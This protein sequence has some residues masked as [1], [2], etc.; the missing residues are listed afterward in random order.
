MPNNDSMNA[1]KKEP[2]NNFFTRY[3]TIKNEMEYYKSYLKGKRVHCIYDNPNSSSFFDY[4]SSNFEKLGLE[5]LSRAWFDGKF[6]THGGLYLQEY[7]KLPTFKYNVADG[8]KAKKDYQKAGIEECI[9]ILDNSD[10]ICIDTPF[11]AFTSIVENI[12]DT[13]KAFIMPT[14]VGKIVSGSKPFSYFVRGKLR[15]GYN[16][17][18]KFKELGK[19]K[20]VSK[21]DSCFITNLQVNRHIEPLYLTMVYDSDIYQKAD[22][23]DVILIHGKR[24]LRHLYPL[25]I[26][27]DYNGYMCVH[28]RFLYYFDPKIWDI[29]E[30]AGYFIKAIGCNYKNEPIKMNNKNGFLDLVIKRKGEIHGC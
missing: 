27:I 6:R 16:I 17:K 18:F 26:P 28:S 2:N 14:S 24:K 25:E 11:S 10:F 12:M 20:P 21:G 19:I 4:F 23:A 1:L 15:L 9:N 7:N 8:N 30:R 5:S 3:D 13:N 22:N 29:V